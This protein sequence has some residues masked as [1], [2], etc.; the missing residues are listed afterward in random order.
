M[1]VRRSWRSCADFAGS[2]DFGGGS[3]YAPAHAQD[4]TQR[5]RTCCFVREPRGR[6]RACLRSRPGTH[7][8]HR[9]AG[10]PRGCP[11]SPDHH[12]HRV[13]RRREG[14]VR[15]GSRQ[16]PLGRP[17][18]REA[19]RGRRPLHVRRTRVRQRRKRIEVPVSG[20]TTTFVRG[21]WP[22]RVINVDYD[23]GPK[24][25]ITVPGRVAGGHWTH[26]DPV[27]R[28]DTRAARHPPLQ[29]ARAA[30]RQGPARMHSSRPRTR[31]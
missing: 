15:E 11:R 30:R 5:P 24:G 27:T 10:G 8:G 22:P 17:G 26:V 13:R 21:T 6:P 23:G 2:G 20:S 9:D 14:T 31:D 1:S 7:L 29:S 3:S 4:E 18:F 19:R 25:K 16:Q 28:V 12:R